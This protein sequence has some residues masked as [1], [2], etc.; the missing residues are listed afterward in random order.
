[1]KLKFTGNVFTGDKDMIK[2]A[3]LDRNGSHHHLF[4]FVV[5]GDNTGGNQNGNLIIQNVI[6]LNVVSDTSMI[7]T[8]FK[9]INPSD[10][11]WSLW[12]W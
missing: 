4:L 2:G 9:I 5:E 12:L 3:K 8:I 1:M 7:K 6:I 10:F 11:M